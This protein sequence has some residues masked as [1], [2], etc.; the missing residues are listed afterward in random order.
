[1]LNFRSRP[2]WCRLCSSEEVVTSRV[3]LAWCG[4]R[5]CV[6]LAAEIAFCKLDA[7]LECELI[8]KSQACSLPLI[9]MVDSCTACAMCWRDSDRLPLQVDVGLRITQI[10]RVQDFVG[11]SS[12]SCWGATP[13]LSLAQFY[14]SSPFGSIP[15]PIPLHLSFLN[16][17]L[18]SF[19][20]RHSACLRRSPAVFL[21]VES[22]VEEW[23]KLPP[24]GCRSRR[25]PAAKC[26]CARNRQK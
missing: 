16:H 17:Y 3:V 4:L 24:P 22:Y 23:N 2:S 6:L 21:I 9:P 5:N 12:P 15:F 26:L 1:M 13:R 10:L 8:R 14:A 18:W 20:F 7:A 11:R 19:H 25:S